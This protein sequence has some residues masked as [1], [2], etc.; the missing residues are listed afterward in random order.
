MG[1]AITIEWRSFLLR[2]EPKTPDQAAFVKYTQSWLRAAE[3]EPAASFQVWATDNPQPSSSLPPHVATKAIELVDPAKT[4]T[5]HRRLLAAYFTE[6]R[7]IS[8]WEVLYALAEEV[9]VAR[10]QLSTAVDEHRETLTET[11]IDE[12]NDAMAQGIT[13]G[14]TTV[15]AGVLPVPGAQ[16]A[17]TLEA[18]VNQ[19][20]E[21]QRSQATLQ[22]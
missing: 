8:D 7:T 3:M 18:L 22:P 21:H 16:D 17:D 19:V 20:I 6:N 2:P 15:I 10:D 9:G 11:V 13:A 14:P 12:H 4:A 5:F 1:A